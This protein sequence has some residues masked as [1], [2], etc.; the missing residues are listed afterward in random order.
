MA[1]TALQDRAP[2]EPHSEAN[3]LL[4]FTKASQ[5]SPQTGVKRVRSFLILLGAFLA[6]FSVA[7]LV[8]SAT[9]HAMRTASTDSH[10]RRLGN[11]ITSDECESEF[12]EYASGV[13]A[14]T[15]YFLSITY[16]FAGLAMVVEG[17][18]VSSIEV[19]VEKLGISEDIAG[20]SWMAAGT[21]AAELF[22]N[23]VDSFVY[24][25]NIGF[26]VIVGTVIFNIFGG[27]GYAAFTCPHDAKKL[28]WTPVARDTACYIFSILIIV[29]CIYDEKVHWYECLVLIITYLLY[30]LL[31]VFHQEYTDVFFKWVIN[32]GNCVTQGPPDGPEEALGGSG[33]KKEESIAIDKTAEAARA[34]EQEMT[35]QG[36]APDLSGASA[37][38][39]P[40]GTA[41]PVGTAD[42]TNDKNH[43]D[44]AAGTDSTRDAEAVDA[45][46][47]RLTDHVG[48][49]DDD[50]ASCS[51]PQMLRRV[52]SELVTE[53][54][55]VDKRHLPSCIAC[56]RIVVSPLRILYKYTIPDVEK[57]KHLWLVTFI[58]SSLWIAFFSFLMVKLG[59][60]IGCLLGIPA[61][62]MGYTFLAVGT[63][64]P[65]SISTILAAQKGQGAMA[66]S[67]TL[68]SNIFD[69]TIALGLP[70][71]IS[72]GT[73]NEAYAIEH[74]NLTGP[75]IWLLYSACGLFCGLWFF[76]FKLR[77]RMGGIFLASYVVFLIFIF[78]ENYAF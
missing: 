63:S 70:W 67:N 56:V 29:A 41:A 11:W 21:S 31:L 64:I 4:P 17:Y 75:I 35:A 16:V 43:S 76:G 32:R 60:S 27:I 20:A 55:Q 1:I 53:E 15:L 54:A 3:M 33:K 6:A 58:N 34:S 65:D 10:A 46:D 57:K 9:K 73:E 52:S 66:V 22:S 25:S 7:G 39:V 47:P 37:S 18:F 72:C 38:A 45:G 69:M 40:T 8:A 36:L 30:I 44:G 49:Q 5:I 26:G 2:M 77:K 42:N 12:E 74:R 71:I 48:T 59:T 13:L 61:V 78:V 51:N 19:I 62:L 23:S 24:K 14:C 68:G 28:N 50:V